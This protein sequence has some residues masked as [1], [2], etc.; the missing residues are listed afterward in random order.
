MNK[1]IAVVSFVLIAAF[2]INAQDMK[3][4]DQG[5]MKKIEE[6]EKVKLIETLGMDEQTTLKFFT[7]RTK[8]R[9]EQSQLIKSTINL[10]DQMSDL[11]K[12]NDGKNDEELKKMIE[13]YQDLEAK[14]LKKK[15]EFYNSLND[16]LTYKQIAKVMVFERR[17]KDEIRAA[18]M[19]ERR[20]G[21]H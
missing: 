21:K 10:I 18:L 14:L 13:Q 16:I 9:E 5:A 12:K 1:L 17:F 4:P 2:V 6:L 3:R 15:L 7:R 8:Y 11:T 20:K 19:Q